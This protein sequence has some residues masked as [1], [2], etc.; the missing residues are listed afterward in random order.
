QIC[1][2]IAEF[3][4]PEELVGR[5]VCA[6]LNL[7]PR[8]IRGAVSNGMVLTAEKDGKLCL[9]EPASPMPNGSRIG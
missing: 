4:K 3:C 1:S 8:K 7:A 5:Q 9:L 6:V 2:G